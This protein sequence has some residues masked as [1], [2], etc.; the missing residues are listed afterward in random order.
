VF[1]TGSLHTSVLVLNG[2]AVVGHTFFDQFFALTVNHCRVERGFGYYCSD[3]LALG[4][5]EGSVLTRLPIR[6]GCGGGRTN[7]VDN[8]GRGQVTLLETVVVFIGV[9]SVLSGFGGRL[10]SRDC[11]S[12]VAGGA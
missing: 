5:R 10:A 8:S 7:Q 9:G 1:L 12:E 11:K 4:L 2:D 3:W 6:L